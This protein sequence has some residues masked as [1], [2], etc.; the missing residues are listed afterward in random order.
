MKI[1]FKQKDQRELEFDIFGLKLHIK[2]D[3]YSNRHNGVIIFMPSAKSEKYTSL[4]PYFPRQKWSPMLGDYCVVYLS[5][6]GDLLV[7]G[8]SGGSWFFNRE[9]SLLPVITNIIRDIFSNP[10]QRFFIYGSSMGGYGGMILGSLLK[11][12]WVI[13]ECHNRFE[14]I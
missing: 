1:D 4:Y 14:E 5:D 3:R 13:A 6:P 12:K 11:A 2:I 10:T 9:T 7:R 8:I